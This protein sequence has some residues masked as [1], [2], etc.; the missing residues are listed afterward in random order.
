MF[1][2]FAVHEPCPR[3]HRSN[4]AAAQ[5]GDD[6][7]PTSLNEGRGGAVVSVLVVMFHEGLK[8][9][10]VGEWMGAVVVVRAK[11]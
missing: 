5:V 11:G 9:R 8:R 3:F 6:V 7:A 1:F 4:D 2:L 10:L